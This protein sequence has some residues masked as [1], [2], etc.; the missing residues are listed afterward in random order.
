MYS[1]ASMTYRKVS[2]CPIIL[3][4]HELLACSRSSDSGMCHSPLSERLEQGLI[5]SCFLL[6][7]A[8]IL[9]ETPS[10]SIHDSP[11][12]ADEQDTVGTFPAPP[13][14]NG[15]VSCA[16]APPL[17]VPCVSNHRCNKTYWRLTP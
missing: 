5:N 2:F 13:D 10:L 15:K 14:P 8:Q 16:L 6:P 3:L 11:F 4:A 1:F 17:S 9:A 7:P 12:P